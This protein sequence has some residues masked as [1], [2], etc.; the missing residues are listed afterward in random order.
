MVSNLSRNSQAGWNLSEDGQTAY[1]VSRDGQEESRKGSILIFLSQVIPSFPCF[2]VTS[3]SPCLTVFVVSLFYSA[4]DP[5]TIPSTAHCLLGLQCLH[6]LHLILPI[7]H[8]W[9]S[10]H[11]GDLLFCCIH[12]CPSS[13]FQP[14]L[15][16]HHL[17][18][19]LLLLHCTPGLLL[20]VCLLHLAEIIHPHLVLH[21]VN[22]CLQQPMCHKHAPQ[23]FYFILSSARFKPATS[24]HS[25]HNVL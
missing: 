25:F 9:H 5:L 24:V 13:L 16:C 18:H 20:F 19:I 8:R 17:C 23:T 21:I 1:S 4:S 22:C 7:I 3:P 6:H 15:C 14:L 10:K 2:T 12:Q 11:N